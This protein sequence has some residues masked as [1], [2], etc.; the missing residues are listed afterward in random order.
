MEGYKRRFDG[1]MDDDHIGPPLDAT[2]KQVRNIVPYKGGFAPDPGT[3]TIPT[4]YHSDEPGVDG[5]R[6]IMRVGCRGILRKQPQ[7]WGDRHRSKSWRERRSTLVHDGDGIDTVFVG[8]GCRI[9]LGA[10]VPGVIIAGEFSG[11]RAD[12]DV[13]PAGFRALGAGGGAASRHQEPI[14]CSASDGSLHAGRGLRSQ[15]DQA[16]RHVRPIRLEW[17]ECGRLQGD[18]E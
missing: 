17:N 15:P 12:V 5:K 9:P 4:F 18:R 1:W 2:P 14:R 6:L 8:T 11:D 7:R 13:P 10:V 16:Y 3:G